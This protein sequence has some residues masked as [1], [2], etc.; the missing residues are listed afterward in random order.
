MSPSP[1]PLWIRPLITML[2]QLG[3][4]IHISKIFGIFFSDPLPIPS[5]ESVAPPPTSLHY[6]RWF[7]QLRPAIKLEP[8][9][10]A[11]PDYCSP[12][13]NFYVFFYCVGY[14]YL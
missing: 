10:A 14:P 9:A 12:P 5:E 4:A 13:S 6:A 11:E 2:N 7:T 1:P 8:E 3:V